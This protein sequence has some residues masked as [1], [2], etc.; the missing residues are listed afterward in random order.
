MEGEPEVGTSSNWFSNRT[1]ETKG[2]SCWSALIVLGNAKTL[3]GSALI[4]LDDAGAMSTGLVDRP[5]K[6]KG[7]GKPHAETQP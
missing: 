3:A 1:L 4:A 6:V 2:A 7:R 5:A